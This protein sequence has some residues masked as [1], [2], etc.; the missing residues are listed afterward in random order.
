MKND[1]IEKKPFWE[2]IV[3]ENERKTYKIANIWKMA[4]KGHVYRF[5]KLKAFEQQSEVGLEELSKKRNLSKSLFIPFSLTVEE[6]LM[7]LDLVGEYP[8]SILKGHA[9]SIQDREELQRRFEENKQSKKNSESEVAEMIKYWKNATIF[10]EISFY[11]ESQN[12][13][14]IKE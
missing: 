14:K 4:L 3:P 12:K 9:I 11:H 1:S 6:R 13:N 2:M 7:L 5:S 10:P 8:L